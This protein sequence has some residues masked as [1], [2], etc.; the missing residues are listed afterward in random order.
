MA[1]DPYHIMYTGICKKCGEE[2]RL[3]V[4]GS[5]FPDMCCRCA[6]KLRAELLYHPEDKGCKYSPK[7]VECPLPE[8]R[9]VAVDRIHVYV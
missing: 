3:Y 7:C 8:C 4:A 5:K 1:S 6:N 9:Y 2:R